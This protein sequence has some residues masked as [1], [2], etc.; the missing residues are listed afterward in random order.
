MA[1]GLDSLFRQSRPASAR[2][3]RCRCGS[4][5]RSSAP[6]T[7]FTSSPARCD[8]QM[9]LIDALDQTFT[10]TRAVI[11]GVRPEQLDD[12][13][14]CAEWTVRD[15]LEHM[16]G[17]VAGLGGAAAGQPRTPFELGDDPARQFD[18]AAA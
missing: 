7:C 16:I 8:R 17:V 9:D 2:C 18:A 13:T 1:P 14:P 11:A 4:A 5:A 15:L 6:S 12:K 3:T 10:Q